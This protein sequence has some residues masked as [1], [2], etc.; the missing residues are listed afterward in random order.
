[1]RQV[2]FVTTKWG[3]LHTIEDGVQH[4]SELKAKFWAPMIKLE[5]SV[6]NL[7]PP[8]PT[9]AQSKI[10]NSR[11]PWDIIHELIVSMNAR[12]IE[13]I[14]LIQEELVDKKFF[15]WETQAGRELRVKLEQL[16]QDTKSLRREAKTRGYSKERLREQQEKIDDL[17]Q[18]LLL[19]K[20]SMGAR[21][22]RWFWGAFRLN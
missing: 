13:L 19:L 15:L 1:M 14:L 16:L 5:A 11:S 18:Q 12:N 8:S 7:Q 21:F 6:F 22:K 9:S 4:V 3:K 2:S 17:T 10:E 20:P